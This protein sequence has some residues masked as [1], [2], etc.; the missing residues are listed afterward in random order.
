MKLMLFF[1]DITRK[2]KTILSGQKANIQTR[3]D[4]LDRIKKYVGLTRNAIRERDFDKIGR[5]L[6]QSWLEKKKLS[7]GISN[8]T[9]DE[10]YDR[11]L[12]TGAIGGKISG[13]GGGGFLLLY[14]PLKNQERL[15][16]ELHDLRELHF[17]L[18]PYGS[19]VIFNVQREVFK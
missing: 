19:R 18:E 5:L 7:K 10:L 17:N 12:A 15:R 13:A 6:D 2:S 9:I 1:T 3:L 11:A 8:K 4:E 16:R 14:C